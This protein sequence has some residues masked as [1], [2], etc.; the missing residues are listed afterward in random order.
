MLSRQKELGVRRD[1]II[2][3]VESRAAATGDNSE[4]RKI[5]QTSCDRPLKCR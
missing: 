3:S 2:E 1:E 4:S 5:R